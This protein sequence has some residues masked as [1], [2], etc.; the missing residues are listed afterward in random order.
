[1]INTRTVAIVALG[2]ALSLHS[3]NGQGRPQYRDF[4]LGGDLHSVSA[5]A[6]VAASEA[7]TIHQRPAVMQELEWRPPYF[8]NGSIAPQT[9]PVHQ[10]VF[11]FYN[12]QLSK[13]VVDYDHDRTAGMTD[14][15]LIEAIS[16][17]Y[18]PALKPA[19]KKARTV[20]SQLEEESGTPV[21]RWGDT[22]YSVVLYRSSYASGFR[23]IVTSPRLEALARTADAQAI[24]L[25]EREAPQ[26]E[27][28]R[29]KKEAEDTRL[30]QEKA[31]IAN[32]AAFQP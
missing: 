27:I 29:Q 10:I 8:V 21:A 19:A 30:S 17:A 9:D 5:V 28:T 6:G 2:L 3:L 32:K 1:M 15:D 26:R 12:D 18:G 4:Q 16:T 22:D 11:S 31:R 13:M 20:V 14:A 24:R 25:D 23:I 7:K